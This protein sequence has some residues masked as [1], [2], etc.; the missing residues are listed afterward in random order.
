MPPFLCIG[1]TLAFFYSDG[2]SHFIIQDLK[3]ISKSLHNDLPQ[4][5]II[6]ILV[7]SWPC[8][9]FGF[10]FW[11]IFKVSS[12]E[13]LMNVSNWPVRSTKLV[14][15][16]LL[17]SNIERILLFLYVYKQT[18]RIFKVRMSKTV[19]GVMMCN[20]RFFFFYSLFKVDIQHYV[21]VI[22]LVTIY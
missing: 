8:A 14:G 3:I 11:I 10:K 9:L 2:Y 18:S 13:K 21:I 17:F 4:I 1:T 5:L 12:W 19:K 7:L 15:S 20:L 6:L 22:S 16:L